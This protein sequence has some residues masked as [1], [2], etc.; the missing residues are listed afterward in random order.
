MDWFHR[1]DTAKR[2]PIIVIT[3]LEGMEN[4]ERAASSGRW[5]FST[6]PSITTTCS[7]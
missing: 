2:I 1:L 4:K 5:R 3:G 7:K 6:S